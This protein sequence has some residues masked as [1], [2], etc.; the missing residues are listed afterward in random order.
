MLEERFGIEGF[1]HAPILH[2]GD[3]D[4][5]LLESPLKDQGLAM[6]EIVE[7]IPCGPYLKEVYASMDWVDRY[8][9]GMGTL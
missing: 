7:N 1:D 4:L 2:C 3:H 5:L 8:M 6:M 9:I